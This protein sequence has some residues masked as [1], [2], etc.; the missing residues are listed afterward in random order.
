MKTRLAIFA[1][2]PIQYQAPI[3]R[4]LANTPDLE[5]VVYYFNDSFLNGVIDPGFGVSVTWDVPLLEG[6]NNEFLSRDADIA[7]PLSVKIPH[8]DTILK[9]GKFDWVMLEG[10][11]YHFE[12]QVIRAA[13]RIGIKV[14]MRGEFSDLR[15]RNPLKTFIRNRYLKW[16]Y[17]HVESFC[18]IG[19]NAKRHL[20]SRNINEKKLFFSPYNV[21]TDLLREQNN[22]FDRASTR[23]RLGLS[24]KHVTFLFSGKLIPR[25]EPL[26]LLDAIEKLPDHTNVALIILGDGPLKKVVL[27]RGSALLGERFLFQGFVNQS[28]LGQY[29]LAADVF[30]HPSNHETWGL[31]VNEAM[32]FGLPAIVSDMVGCHRDLVVEGVTGYVFPSGDPDMLASCMQKLFGNKKLSKKLGQNAFEKISN[33]STQ[34]AAKGILNAIGCNSNN[35][36]NG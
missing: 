10:Y 32:Q 20:L 1:T 3:W 6:Y 30:V 23:L 24:D 12:R 18:Y 9:K 15:A 35:S 34:Y 22:I 31:V 11:I 2:H 27:E 29:F 16:F 4:Q 33:Y 21:D 26:L 14:V 17:S 28:Q 19:E 5:V 13:K 7:R 8:I 25:K 36:E